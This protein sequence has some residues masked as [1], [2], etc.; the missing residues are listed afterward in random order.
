MGGRRNFSQNK[1]RDKRIRLIGENIGKYPHHLNMTEKIILRIPK[2]QTVRHKRRDYYIKIKTIMF[3]IGQHWWRK[4]RK[5]QPLR[6]LYDSFLKPSIVSAYDPAT[7]HPTRYL[8]KWGD[9]LCPYK[10]L[11]WVLT[12]NFQKLEATKTFF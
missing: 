2:T 9:N 7:N 6:I 4:Y 12:H 8:L 3:I 11:Q 5:A 10:N 1:F